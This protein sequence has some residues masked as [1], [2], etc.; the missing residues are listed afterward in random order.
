MKILVTGN[1]N[2][3]VAESICKIYPEAKFKSKTGEFDLTL[4]DGL[5]ILGLRPAIEGFFLLV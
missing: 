3:G 5:S 1:P 2:Y 4:V